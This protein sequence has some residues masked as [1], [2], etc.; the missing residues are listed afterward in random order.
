MKRPRCSR[1]FGMFGMIGLLAATGLSGGCSSTVVLRD[2]AP[3]PTLPIRPAANAAAIVGV[4]AA[5]GAMVERDLLDRRDTSLALRPTE[6]LGMSDQWQARPVPDVTRIR[7][8]QFAR[9]SEAFTYFE[10]ER[11]GGLQSAR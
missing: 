7:R 4:G 1:L 5:A 8:L 6:R 2:A 9:S 3:A 11:L 10:A